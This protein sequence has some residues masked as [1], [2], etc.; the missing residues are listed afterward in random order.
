MTDPICSLCGWLFRLHGKGGQCPDTPTPNTTAVTNIV[1]FEPRFKEKRKEL[2]WEC[3]C[4]G[5]LFFLNIDGSIACRSCN[6]TRTSLS[7][8]EAK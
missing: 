1:E 7:W 5:Q 4:G 3:T 2:V 6:R 8:K